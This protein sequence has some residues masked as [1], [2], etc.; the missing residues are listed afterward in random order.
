MKKIKLQIA[1]LLCAQSLFAPFEGMYIGGQA[2]LQMTFCQHSLFGNPGDTKLVDK[3]VTKNKPVFGVIFGYAANVGSDVSVGFEGRVNYASCE[4]KVEQNFS[5]PLLGSQNDELWG[6]KTMDYNLYGRVFFLANSVI[7]YALVGVTFAPW[8][9]FYRSKASNPQ[10]G[11]NDFEKSNMLTSFALGGGILIS[12][13]T[14]SYIGCEATYHFPSTLKNTFVNKND[15]EL[16][17]SAKLHSLNLKLS[18][19]HLF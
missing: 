12:C 7:P 2:G 18:Y 19:V 15:I 16:K 4:S 11:N 9:L 13:D 17:Q 6:T 10:V 14:T 8:K 1:F 3:K 5:S